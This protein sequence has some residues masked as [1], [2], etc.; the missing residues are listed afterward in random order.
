MTTSDTQTWGAAAPSGL[1][2]AFLEQAR[3][4]NSKAWSRMASLLAPEAVDVERLGFRARLHPKDNL[5]EKRILYTPGRFDPVELAH[6]SSRIG[7]DFTFVDLGANCGGYTLHLAA[8][9]PASARFFAIE[10]QP[11]MARRFRFNL[12]ANAFA[13][14]VQLDEVAI[15]DKRGDI[16]FTINTHNRG[17]SGLEGQG[18]SI[19]VP[20]LPLADYLAERPIERLDAMKIDVEGLEHRILTSFFAAAPK[21]C[22]PRCLIVE[23]LFSTP[24][25]D[26]VALAVSLGYHVERDLGRNVILSLT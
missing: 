13:A 12:G 19:S 3:S 7:P 26:P 20:A 10:A 18:E 9:A 17:E 25:K 23:Q 22:W 21:S 2:R 8:K 1:F 24:E 11:E 5:S 14:S 6:L 4:R 15:S 16:S